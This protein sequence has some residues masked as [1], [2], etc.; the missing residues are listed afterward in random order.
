MAQKNA[1]SGSTFFLD[2]TSL[3][4]G[5]SDTNDTNYVP[6]IDREVG[7]GTTSASVT[8]IYPSKDRGL[9]VR[10]RR[11]ATTPILPF[12][13]QGTFGSTGFSIATIRTE[14]TIVT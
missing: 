5:Y 6:Y 8:V 1:F 10:V 11:K 12:E 13:A 4:K 3:T 14:D 7:A 9:L 2:T